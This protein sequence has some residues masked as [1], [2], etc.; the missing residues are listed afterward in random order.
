VW[1]RH[2]GG[3]FFGSYF[4]AAYFHSYTNSSVGG[5]LSIVLRAMPTYYIL[6]LMC[7]FLSDMLVDRQR[8]RTTKI[9]A[10]RN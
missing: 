6:V 7:L 2:I 1:G 3:N 9:M 5:D 8:R 10:G 4:L